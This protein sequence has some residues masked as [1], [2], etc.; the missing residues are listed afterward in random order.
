MQEIVSF[1]HETTADL[2]RLAEIME[3]N[4]SKCQCFNDFSTNFNAQIVPPPAFH[5]PPVSSNT[6]QPCFVPTGANAI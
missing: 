4:N 2:K 5:Y 3:E 6:H 1:D